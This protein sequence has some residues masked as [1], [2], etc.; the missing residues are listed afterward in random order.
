MMNKIF[1][2]L[3]LMAGHLMAQDVQEVVQVEVSEDS[4]WARAIRLTGKFPLADDQEKLNRIDSS[5]LTVIT[6][7]GFEVYPNK[8]KTR[9]DGSIHYQ[10]KMEIKEGKYRISFFDFEYQPYERNRYS[11]YVPVRGGKVPFESGPYGTKKSWQRHIDRKNEVIKRQINF[12]KDFM[13]YEK[14]ENEKN[15]DD[16]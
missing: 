10:F 13:V 4:L 9:V 11:R 16:W 6:N 12:I 14:A 2:F 8:L 5:V 3:F 7:A 1:L 15:A